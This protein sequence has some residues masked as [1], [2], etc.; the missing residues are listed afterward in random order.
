MIPTGPA[1]GGLVFAGAAPDSTGAAFSAVGLLARRASSMNASNAYASYGSRRPSALAALNSSSTI[2]RCAARN[3]APA[4]TGPRTTTFQPPSASMNSFN[5]LA[6]RIR[7]CAASRSFARARKHLSRTS[8]SGASSAPSNRSASAS[9][10]TSA[11]A[12]IASAFAPD[13]S[14]L[15]SA[16]VGLRELA[17]LLRRL[18][19]VPRRRHRRTRDRRQL[20][21]RRRV[22]VTLPPARLLHLPRQQQLRRV[23]APLDRVERRP[24]VDHLAQRHRVGIDPRHQHTKELVDLANVIRERARRASR[25]RR[26]HATNATEGVRQ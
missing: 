21:R 6:L 20:L 8:A 13:N 18:Q 4:S 26:D 16:W 11:A 24:Q 2:G 10:A 25:K 23:R 5:D 22:P 12:A 14:P 15:R 1:A 19:L 7:A 3:T 9:G 17:D